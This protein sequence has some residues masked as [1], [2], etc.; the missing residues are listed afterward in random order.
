MEKIAKSFKDLLDDIAKEQKFVD[1]NVDIKEISSG[2]A[3]YTS[4]LFS[5]SIT[6]GT[7]TL[8][9]FCK[10]A[11]IGEQMRMQLAK[12]YETEHFFY[13]K[14]GKIYRSIEDQCGIPHK[15]KL[16]VSKYYGSITKLNEEVMV[17]EDLVAAG[18]EA[19]DRFKSIDWPYAHAAVRELAKFHACSWAYAKQDPEEFDEVMKKVMFDVE[20]NN[21]NMQAFMTSMVNK[22]IDTVHDENK[23]KLQKYFDNFDV[24]LYTDI[25]K[26]SRR[27]V[28]GHGDFRP[29]NLMHKNLDDGSVV[30][31]VVDLQTLQGGSPVTDLIYFIFTGSDEKFRA[32]YFDKLLDHYYSELSAAMKR[33]HLNPEKTFSQ[34]DF[35]HE[36]KEKLPVGL[37]LAAFTLPVVTVEVENA[38][39]VDESLDISKFNLEKT[40]DLYAERLNGVVND[41]VKWG[42]LT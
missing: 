16:N 6:E 37:M 24:E 32:R 21:E 39:Q 33:L 26:R 36:M 14:L 40:S 28:L 25:F 4:K 9:L 7:R 22:A 34:E 10:V 27:L 31:K 12:I 5:V 2:G 1:Y 11:A 38:P 35:D 20:F 30:I 19:Y 3:N 23:S 17:L 18:Y 42:I 41:Y 29:S 13:T 15:L 8:R